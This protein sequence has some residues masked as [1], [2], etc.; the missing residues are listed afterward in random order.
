MT[1]KN[2][3]KKK[4]LGWRLGMADMKIFTTID[5]RSLGEKGFISCGGPN[6]S[7]LP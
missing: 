7:I 2:G 4:N 1:D 6:T 3:D 5:R